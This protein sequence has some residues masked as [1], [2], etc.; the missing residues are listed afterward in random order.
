[1]PGRLDPGRLLDEPR[2]VPGGP[3][4]ASAQGADRAERGPADHERPPGRPGA[5][6]P[7]AGVL[8]VCSSPRDGM[9]GLIDL[10]G[11]RFLQAVRGARAT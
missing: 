7:P 8:S 4:R 9:L 3:G 6:P 11:H 5:G 2:L 10:I 1:M